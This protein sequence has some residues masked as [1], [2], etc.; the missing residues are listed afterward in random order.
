MGIK[1][2]SFTALKN[3]VVLAPAGA[4]KRENFENVWRSDATYEKLLSDM[5]RLR[6]R[7]YVRDGAI[8]PSA[9]T[10]DGRHKSS[11]DV[12]SWHLLAL[13]SAG[14]VLGCMRIFRP[15][16]TR[17]DTLNLR[18]AALVRS[19]SWCPQLYASIRSELSAARIAG[20]SYI[21]IGGWALT[22][23]LRGTTEAL[24]AVLATYAW[25]QHIGGALGIAT[26]TER[27]GSRFILRRLGGKPFEWNG[28]ELPPYEDNQYRCKM[29]L[30]R[31][32][33]RAP[34]SKYRDVVD[35]MRR[36]FPKIAVVCPTE[37]APWEGIGESL[38][39]LVSTPLWTEELLAG[40]C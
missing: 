17:F 3:L 40:F 14:R 9:L 15:N 23:E 39:R 13:N 1:S 33:S 30:L 35:S 12:R 31:F 8:E 26:A 6:G 37:S 10:A 29:E 2:E 38:R 36:Q 32:D 22:E 28:E 7:I 18:R 16:L 21:E 34:D 27:N 5:Q 4:A 20:F 25:A 24:R 11:C 19:R